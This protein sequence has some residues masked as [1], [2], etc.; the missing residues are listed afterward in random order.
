MNKTLTTVA[1]IAFL[2][3]AGG[4]AIAVSYYGRGSSGTTT[5]Q[6]ATVTNQALANVPY[7]SSHLPF[8]PSLLDSSRRSGN[9]LYRRAGNTGIAIVDI[10]QPQRPQVVGIFANDLGV[11]DVY[12]SQSKA[13][14]VSGGTLSS[15]SSHYRDIL[16]IYDIH[17]PLHPTQLGRYEY[18]TALLTG[19]TRIMVAGTYAYV[20]D[21]QN[22]VFTL[23]VSNSAKPQLVGTYK[24]TFTS[25]GAKGLALAG[26]YL[27]VAVGDPGILILDASQPA[28]L[29]YVG[30][31]K[32][33][34]FPENLV[35]QGQTLFFADYQGLG[36]T[37]VDVTNPAQ[38]KS[39][40]SQFNAVSYL[41]PQDLLVANSRVYG[42]N[43]SDGTCSVF[44]V[45]TPGKIVP[46]T[47]ACQ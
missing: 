4:V 12:F 24:D 20:T 29:Q 40:A 14:I 32:G 21:G 33:K 11:N 26:H 46:L 44:D 45:S 23:D 3:V 7:A 13:Y 10:S 19:M 34:G 47:A 39:L 28:A 43:E 25:F 37:E 15:R 5:N 30:T 8:N 27:Y 31:Y 17:D 22:Q 42:F 41:S 36:I 6:P 18:P 38:P 9:Y 35:V 2:V 1:F 16:A